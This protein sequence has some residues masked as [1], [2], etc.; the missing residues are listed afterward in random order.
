VNTPV[1]IVS[2]AILERPGG[3]PR[4]TV[5]EMVFEVTTDAVERSRIPRS[6][7]ELTISGSSDMLDGRS[8]N[9]AHALEAMGAHPATLE[10][11]LEMDGAFAAYAAWLKIL[12]KEAKSALVVAFSKAS[13]GSLHHVLNA[14]LDPFFLAPLGLDHR[15]SAALQADAWCARTGATVEPLTAAP[16]ADGACAIVLAEEDLARRVCERPIWIRGAD[17]RTDSGALGERDLGRL[18][19]AS[20]ALSRAREIA[21]WGEGGVDVAELAVSFG[22]QVWM[23]KEALALDDRVVVRPSFESLAPDPLMVTGLIRLARCVRQ[24]RG[25]AGADQVAGAKRGLAHAASGHALQ[26]NLVWLLEA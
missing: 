25:E 13:E 22:H 26:Q 16:V 21:G 5:Q 10:S 7:I 4:S 6:E 17:H 14:Q 19:G 9:F 12:A 11:H 23:L 20:L 15:A 2:T 3:D 18:E 24:L 8:F 1:A